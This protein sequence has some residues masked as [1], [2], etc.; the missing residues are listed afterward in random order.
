MT[1]AEWCHRF[2]DACCVIL[3]ILPI[4]YPRGGFQLLN[5]TQWIRIERAYLSTAYQESSQRSNVGDSFEIP[6]GIA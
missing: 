5:P 1:A 4:G 2:N 6:N 3:V